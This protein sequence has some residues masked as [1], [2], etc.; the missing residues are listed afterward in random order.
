MLAIERR[1][2][3]REQAEKAKRASEALGQS[4]AQDGRA[5]ADAGADA[6]KIDP[7]H[8]ALIVVIQG[9]AGVASSS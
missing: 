7:E 9:R 6:V 2:I 1:K 5:D 8:V 4:Q 3:E